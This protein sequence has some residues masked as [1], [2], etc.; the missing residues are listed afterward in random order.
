MYISGLSN[1]GTGTLDYVS[2]W[3]QRFTAAVVAMGAGLFGFIEKGG[4]R[5]FVSNVTHT[6]MLF[7]HGKRDEVINVSATTNTVDSLRAQHADVAMKL[8]PERGHE[9]APGSGR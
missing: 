9:I 8:F 4:N 7:L 3:P 2:L 5:P 6:P 1:G